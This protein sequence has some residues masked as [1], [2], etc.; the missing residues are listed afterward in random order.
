MK[1]EEIIEATNKDKIIQKVIECIK[2]NDFPNDPEILPFKHIK[3]DLSVTNRG[4]LLRD[5][6]MVIPENLRSKALEL[7]HE[8]HQ[9]I[10]KKKTA[11]RASLV[12]S[13]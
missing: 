3:D 11:T 2:E 10:A 12:S 13:H 1:I 5:T 4:I 7:A 8:G 6:R 9:G